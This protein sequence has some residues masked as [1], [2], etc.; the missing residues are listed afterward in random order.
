MVHMYTIGLMIYLS[1]EKTSENM[2]IV[3]L[4]LDHEIMI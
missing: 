4:E 1:M 3:F 2:K